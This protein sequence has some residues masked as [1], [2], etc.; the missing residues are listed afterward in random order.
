MGHAGR[1]P[2]RLED[3]DEC[4]ERARR[5]LR[6]RLPSERG[7]NRI[8]RLF[9]APPSSAALAVR[10]ACRPSLLPAPVTSPRVTPLDSTFLALH[11]NLSPSSRAPQVRCGKG[12]DKPNVNVNS[13]T[14]AR[15]RARVPSLSFR[16]SAA[17][18]MPKL[19][20]VAAGQRT[21]F[22]G[23]SSSSSY[24]SS[25]SR[26]SEWKPDEAGPGRKEAGRKF[27]EWG[28]RAE[29]GVE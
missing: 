28:P 18:L 25:S 4:T 2:G 26:C 14:Q 15:A 3:R 5:H 21:I 17:L 6:A 23:I 29:R 24:S 11:S 16:Q 1:V 19:S 8:T 22:S 10:A 27:A 12:T 20:S 7:V 13:R 9:I